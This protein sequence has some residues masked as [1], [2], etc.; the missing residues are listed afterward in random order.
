M[1]AD[2]SKDEDEEGGEEQEPH[3]QEQTGNRLQVS[4]LIV[5]SAE[6][7]QTRE[8]YSWL[9]DIQGC[10]NQQCMLDCW[11]TLHCNS[12]SYIRICR[13]IYKSFSEMKSRSVAS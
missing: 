8:K 9:F 10:V 12:F 4:N 6:Q 1:Q 2:G 7:Q 11:Y 13:G 3:T 5:T